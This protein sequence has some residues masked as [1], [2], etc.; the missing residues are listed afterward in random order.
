MQFILG[1]IENCV[2]QEV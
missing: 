1:A 2:S